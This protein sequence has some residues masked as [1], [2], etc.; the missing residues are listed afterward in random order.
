MTTLVTLCVNMNRL[1][2]LPDALARLPNLRA[3]HASRNELVSLPRNIGNLSSLRDL[4]LD[5]NRISELPFSFRLLTQLETLCMERNP[6]KLPPLH[7]I[8]R[9]VRATIK[10]MEKSLEEFIK[11]SR[12]EVVEALQAVLT[13]GDNA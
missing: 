3:L 6:L 7:Y 12:R 13:H 10:Y 5:W 8:T 9:G 11:K 4:R 1:V 2:E